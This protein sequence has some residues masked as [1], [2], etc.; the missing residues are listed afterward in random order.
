MADL[1]NHFPLLLGG[2][3]PEVSHF[4]IA[5]DLKAFGVDKLDEPG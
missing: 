5:N 2:E 4:R 3:G 1:M